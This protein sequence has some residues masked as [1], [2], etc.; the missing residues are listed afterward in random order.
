MFAVG[1]IAFGSNDDKTFAYFHFNLKDTFFA[2][3]TIKS[4]LLN[5]DI[6]ATNVVPIH[7][8]CLTYIL[9]SAKIFHDV[10]QTLCI[11]F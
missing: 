2:V 11:A 1:L 5:S 10:L 3:I 9:N 8:F 6:L 4:A 7:V